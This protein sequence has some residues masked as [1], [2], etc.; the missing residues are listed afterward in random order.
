M[1]NKTLLNKEVINK[2]GE[3]YLIK[4][5]NGSSEI[6]EIIISLSN[7]KKYSLYLA[8]RSGYLRFKEEKLNKLMEDYLEFEKEESIRLAK[9]EEENKRKKLEEIELERI[10]LKDAITSFRGEY[11]FLSNFYNASITY[12]GI[13]YLNN[14]AAF[15]AQK[16]LSRSE[17]FKNLSPTSAKRLG[18]KVTLRSD[19]EDI[20]VNIME[21]ILRIKFNTYPDLKEKLIN[22]KDRLLIEGNDWNDTFWGVSKGKGKN[23]LGILLMKLREEYQKK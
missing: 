3:T 22:T 5:T 18:R 6:K 17:E 19:W 8:Y 14:E 13:T 21:D 2:V 16:D 11:D 9:L 20:K 7:D 1:D 15:Q 4:A 10:K 12:N 23:N